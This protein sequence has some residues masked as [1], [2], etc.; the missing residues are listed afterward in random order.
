MEGEIFCPFCGYKNSIDSNYRVNCGKW[1]GD[2]TKQ[3]REGKGKE[4]G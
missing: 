4:E 1:I 3:L 2:L